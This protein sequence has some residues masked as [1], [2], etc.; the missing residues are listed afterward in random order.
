MCCHAGFWWGGVRGRELTGG[1]GP[2]GG[3]PGGRLC[4]SCGLCCV[5]SLSVSLLLLFPLFAVLLNCPYADPPVSACFFPFFSAPRRREGWLR[6][7]F[8]TSRSPNHNNSEWEKTG[9]G[10]NLEKVGDRFENLLFKKSKILFSP[11]YLKCC[12]I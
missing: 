1:S 2:R 12:Q 5:F 10:K 11:P 4:G 9:R 8:V 7:A 6:G 3:G